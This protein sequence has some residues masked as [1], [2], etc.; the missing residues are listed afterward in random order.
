MKLSGI[1]NIREIIVRD[2]K[3]VFSNPI[4]TIVLIGLIILPSLYALLNIQACWDPY[5][6]TG[7]VEFAI[8]NLDKGATFQETNI[9]IGDELVKD[10]KKNDKFKWVF[11]TEDE[12]RDGV[13]TGKYYAGIVIPKN[14]SENVVSITDENPKQAKLEYLVNMKEN[15]VGAKLTDSGSNAV[16][17]SLNA[18]IVEII[19]LAAYGKLG[20]LQEG[21][22]SGASQLASGGSQ[23]QAGA[24]QV[25]DGAGQ[26][27][28]GE[29][30]VKDGSAAVKDGASKV[31][32]GAS[33]VSTGANKVKQ[34]S[35]AVKDGAGQVE[36]GAEE[37]ETAVDPSLIPEGPVKEYAEGVGQLSDGASQVAGGASQLADGSV[38]LAEGSLALAAG[39]Q[40]LS[41]AAAQALFTAAGSLGASANQLAGITGINETIL[42]DYFF[43]PIKLDRH[44]VF[45]VP[46]Y[47][48]QV[49]PFYL[50]LSMWVGGLIT[51]ALLRPGTSHKT[52]YTP[53]E[54]Y[55]GKLVLFNVMS[56]LQVSVTIIGAHILGIYIDNELLFIISSLIVSG[57]FMTLIY[58][59][60]SALGDVGKAVAI[61]LLV[62]QISGTGG[63]YPV[64]I[65][66]P[67][68]NVMNPYLPMTYAI[69]LIRE[70]QLGVIW[71][72]YI[73]ALVLLFAIAIITVVVSILVK[74]RADRITHYFENRLEDSGL[75]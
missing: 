4:V 43:S 1:K 19:N 25:S 15:P 18:K 39:S 64:E 40:L 24:A 49:S 44:E 38:E 7:N 5:G 62:I 54:M 30:Q 41:N 73:P 13:Y 59:F 33:D 10:L 42:G 26:V 45:T 16:Y 61:V 28:D 66:A 50:V 48:S 63:I 51:C 27:A 60:V 75:F 74:E 47:G 35:T 57:V 14:L 36:Q 68:F 46:D 70:A 34:G 37:L 3:G 20:E 29:S 67:F 71:S 23:L 11:V 52:K 9:N 72:N 65:M 8:A 22:A 2:F 31:Q 53:L 32:K 58:S 55:A 6:N 12:L 21:L 56:I 17:N 69:T